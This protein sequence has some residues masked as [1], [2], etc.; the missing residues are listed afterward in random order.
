MIRPMGHSISWF[1]YGTE[2]EPEGS[3][4]LHDAASGKGRTVLTFP[5]SPG[6]N[7]YDSQVSWM[8]DGTAAWVAIPEPEYGLP[9]P[10]NGTTLYRVSGSRTGRRGRPDRRV[11]SLL[12][13]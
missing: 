12:V 2:A 10:P 13:T 3:V 6:K 8:P 11:S 1:E 9:T 4:S 5:A 7:S